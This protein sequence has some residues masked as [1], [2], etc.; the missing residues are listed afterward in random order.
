MR[1]KT[2]INFIYCLAMFLYIDVSIISYHIMHSK[3]D[4]VEIK[5]IELKEEV[6]E[7]FNYPDLTRVTV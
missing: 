2:I 7:L 1:N 4:K 5:K 6:E 3:K